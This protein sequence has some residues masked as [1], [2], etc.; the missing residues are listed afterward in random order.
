MLYCIPCTLL[1][2]RE[3]AC[4]FSI[5]LDATVNAKR[6]SLMIPMSLCAL[7][8]N[9]HTCD[10]SASRNQLLC[11]V[12]TCCHSFDRFCAG[13][14][15]AH[16]FPVFYFYLGIGSEKKKQQ[17]Q[18][19]PRYFRDRLEITNDSHFTLFFETFM[20]GDTYKSIGTKSRM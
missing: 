8:Q 15:Y 4:N 7:T 12:S 11:Y 17:H 3:S 10:H 16:F 18:G 1:D 5:A 13:F 9:A 14:P 2:T 20:V 19:I 6:R